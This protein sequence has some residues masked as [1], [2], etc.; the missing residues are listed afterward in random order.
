[1]YENIMLLEWQNPSTKIPA[2]LLYSP[3][4]VILPYGVTVLNIPENYAL[5]E[6]YEFLWHVHLNLQNNT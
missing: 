3:T 5:L 4:V 2:N 6:N 1:M